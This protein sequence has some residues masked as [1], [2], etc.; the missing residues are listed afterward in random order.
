MMA[1]HTPRL[2]AETPTAL[3]KLAATIAALVTDCTNA[4]RRILELQ[5]GDRRRAS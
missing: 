1:R 3:S 2:G 5:L 4:N